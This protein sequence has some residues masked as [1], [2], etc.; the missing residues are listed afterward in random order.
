MSLA[1][2]L[3]VRRCPGVAQLVARLLWEQDAAGSNPVTRTNPPG[4]PEVSGGI[5][6]FMRLP[7]GSKNRLT[8]M[9]Q[10]VFYQGE[11]RSYRPSF[12]ASLRP[13]STPMTLAIIRPLVQP[14]ESPR[15]CRPRML[16]SRFSSIL[17]LLE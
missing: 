16:V 3:R 5:F 4:D 11:V 1:H 12:S 7:A 14:E 10:P 2:P 17:T 9:R 6:S 13:M 15:Q 8:Q